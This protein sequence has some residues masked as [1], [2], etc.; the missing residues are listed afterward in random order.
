MAVLRERPQRTSAILY[1]LRLMV[2]TTLIRCPMAIALLH[3]S[4]RA[5]E[6]VLFCSA[7]RGARSFGCVMPSV[8]RGIKKGMSVLLASY[9]LL[10]GSS[11]R[12]LEQPCRAKCGMW[13][14]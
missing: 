7:G 10:N 14:Q 13:R 12:H 6:A 3:F 1:W 11:A 4:T 2:V 5:L 8:S 9:E